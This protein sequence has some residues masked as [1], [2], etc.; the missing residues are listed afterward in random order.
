MNWH[1]T[2]WFLRKAAE[3][4]DIALSEAVESKAEETKR[5][6]FDF[7]A[8]ARKLCEESNT[9]ADTQLELREAKRRNGD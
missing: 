8:R 4:S 6:R 7:L 5:D 9:L 1:E 2:D 3:F